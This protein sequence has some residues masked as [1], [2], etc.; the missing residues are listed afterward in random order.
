MKLLVLHITGLAGDPLEELDGRTLLDAAA[1]PALDEIARR[2]SCGTIRLLPEPTVAGAGAE[3]L[4]L[5]GYLE[6]EAAIPSLGPL[7]A[8]AVGAPVGPRDV[9]FRV[10]LGSMAEDGVIRDTLGG[11]ASAEEAL[12]LMERIDA[13]LSNRRLRFY[14]GRHFAH[15]MVWT[16]GPTEV[17]CT[18]A[19]LACGRALVEALPEGD[20]DGALRQLI[21]DSIDLLSGHRLNHRRREEGLPPVDLLWPWAPGRRPELEHYVVRAREQALVLAG[22]LEV[23]GAAKAGGIPTREP[24]WEFGQARAAL[25][26]AAAANGLTWLH[27]D[28]P[29]RFEHPTDPEAHLRAFAALDAELIAPVF[30][31]ARTSAEAVRLILVGTWPEAQWTPRPPALWGVWPALRNEGGLDV[32]TEAALREEGARVDETERL[33]QEARSATR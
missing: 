26:E 14:P 32:F 11:G 17:R 13:K 22:R 27:V 6:S 3:L 31:E 5:L 19:P 29:E 16:D 20:G 12:V 15:V 23:Q 2:G 18:P 28:L 30:T 25:I 21:W 9:A 33:L 1:T 8:V 24:P 10:N 7:E 4:S